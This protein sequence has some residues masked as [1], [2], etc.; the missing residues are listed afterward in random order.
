VKRHRA[1][2]GLCLRGSESIAHT[3]R[4][5]LTCIVLASRSDQVRAIIS[6]R[7]DQC[8]RQAIP[9]PGR[10]QRAAPARRWN[11]SGVRTSLSR[12]RFDEVIT[13]LMGFKASHSYRMAWLYSADRMLFSFAFKL[14]ANA[15]ECNHSSMCIVRTAQSQRCPQR[16]SI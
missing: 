12:R 15:R 16:G 10:A 7:V 9:L 6:D 5:T 3:E 4:K 14:G 2:R 8:Y 11:S 13:L 1:A